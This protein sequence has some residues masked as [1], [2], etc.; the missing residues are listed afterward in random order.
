MARYGVVYNTPFK[1]WG[2]SV[3]TIN[4]AVIEATDNKELLEKLREIVGDAKLCE[5]MIFDIDYDSNLQEFCDQ[6][7]WQPELCQELDEDDD[8]EMTGECLEDSY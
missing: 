7:D 6:A 8:C 3:T 2:C 5:V 1:D 4:Y